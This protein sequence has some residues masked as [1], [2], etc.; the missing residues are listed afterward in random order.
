MNFRDLILIGGGHPSLISS[1]SRSQR[2]IDMAVV[3]PVGVADGAGSG[4]PNKAAGCDAASA[5]AGACS[6]L[7]NRRRGRSGRRKCA[8][9]FVP[10]GRMPSATKANLAITIRNARTKLKPPYPST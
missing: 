6:P 2:Q 5:V 7:A 1:G 10:S 8:A 3:V 4:S 9:A